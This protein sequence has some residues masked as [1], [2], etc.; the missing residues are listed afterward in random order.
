MFWGRKRHQDR[1][2]TRDR[3]ELNAMGAE[4]L[5]LVSFEFDKA[6]PLQQALVGTFFFG[7]VSA[8]G[9]AAKRTLVEVHALALLAFQDSLHYTPA[10]A[11]QAVQACIEA[12]EPGAHDTMDAVL[13]RSIDGHAQFVAGDIDGLAGNL[14]SILD[15]FGAAEP[16]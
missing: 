10:A 8:H 3:D 12:T 7:M 9:M 16:T 14:R 6:S 2:L 11:T 15:H 13:H 5:S 4:L 1:N